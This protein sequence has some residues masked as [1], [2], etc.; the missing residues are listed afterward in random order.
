MDIISCLP[1]DILR[2]KFYLKL[3]L[4]DI[5]NLAQTNSSLA[6]L[7]RDETLW[8]SR[9]GS[10]FP[11][12]LIIKPLSINWRDYY[13]LLVTDPLIPLFYNGDR[14]AY[15]PLLPG[16]RNLSL[17]MI[18]YYIEKHMLEEKNQKIH[19]S[20][21]NKNLQEVSTVVYWEGGIR[22]TLWGQEKIF[23]I[24]IYVADQSWPV[25]IAT[26]VFSLRGTPPI[27]GKGNDY[28]NHFQLYDC[29]YIVDWSLSYVLPR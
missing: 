27:Y 5:D 20:F 29:R 19:I 26:H 24:L 22:G 4:I 28:D 11:D 7:T 6:E 10:E 25:T 9:V 1:I 8:Q 16:S 21:I 23:R 13:R 3:N 17:S 15:I 18:S 14:I 2:S 12:L